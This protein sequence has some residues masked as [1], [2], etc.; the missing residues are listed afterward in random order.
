MTFMAVS[1]LE[2]VKVDVCD[3]FWSTQ[4]LSKILHIKQYRGNLIISLN[5]ADL[6]FQDNYIVFKQNI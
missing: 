6:I 3:D 5:I 2:F 1:F 4:S